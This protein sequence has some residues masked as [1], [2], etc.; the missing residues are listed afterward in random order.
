MPDQSACSLTSPS[1]PMAGASN[2]MAQPPAAVAPLRAPKLP[3]LE[4]LLESARLLTSTLSLQEVLERLAET[5]R[6]LLGADVVEIWLLDGAGREPS[7]EAHLGAMNQ[8]ADGD[9]RRRSVTGGLPEWI[10]S[11]QQPVTLSDM[12]QDPRLGNPAWAEAEGLIGYLGVLLTMETKPLGV[13]VCMTRI[14]REFGVE[15][16]ALAETLASQG[17]I[18]ICNARFHEEARAR[19]RQL[20]ERNRQLQLLHGVARAITAEPELDRLLQR[21]LDTARELLAARLGA[22]ALSVEEGRVRRFFTAGWTSR[23]REWMGPLLEGRGPGQV[24]QQG[25]SLRLADLTTHPAAGEFASGRPPVGSLLAVP[26]RFRGETLGA[27]YLF[28][29]PGGFTADD[30]KLLTTLCGDAAVAVANARLLA[31]EQLRRREAHTLLEI[32]RATGSTL[33]QGELVTLIAREAARACRVDRCSIFLRDESGE[34][35]VP[36]MSQFAEGSAD[37]GTWE[38]FRSLGQLRMEA[39]PFFEEAVRRKEPVPVANAV[40]D[41]LVPPEWVARFRLKSVLAVPLIHP[42]GVIGVLVLD[43]MVEPRPFTPEQVRLAVTL[44]GH[45]ALTLENARLVKSLRQ[46]LGALQE[47]NAELDNFVYCV[48]HDLKAPLVTIQG[49]SSILLDDYSEQ[50]DPEARHYLQRIQANIEQMEQFITDLLLLSRVGREG[51]AREP[52]HLAELV[53]DFLLGLA[54][55]IRVRGIKMVGK[56]LGT[57][58]A[59]RTQMEQVIGNLLSN[60]VKYIGDVSSPMVE[61]GTVGRGEFVECYVKDNGIGIDPAYHQRIFEIFQ[62]LKEVGAEGTGVGLAIAKKI[63]ESAGG[64]IWVESTKGQG[65]TFRFTWP[66]PSGKDS[67]GSQ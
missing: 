19:A 16:I 9:H 6:S 65:A 10:L 25:K 21:L 2:Q 24:I 40:M 12:R 56:N 62:R 52:V 23:A 20:E 67:H 5:A 42:N 48:S 59:I 14:P 27:L 41:P 45:V 54:E 4:A 8:E 49:M 11:H 39:I 47:K 17:A 1:A 31:E 30:E 38:T 61:I 34:K 57:I 3:D 46:A 28:E 43:Y 7:L 35:V 26:I 33:E 13:L 63:V 60:A 32:A 18:A 15:E 66:K 55:P 44:A 58:W 29:K 36:V 22:L 53:D 51:Q 37:R 64:R 50:L